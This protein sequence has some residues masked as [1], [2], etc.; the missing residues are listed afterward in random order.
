MQR[1]HGCLIERDMEFLAAQQKG[2]QL[3]QL[4]FV[5]PLAPLSRPARARPAARPGVCP[6]GQFLVTQDQA[7]VQAIHA[8]LSAFAAGTQQRA[9]NE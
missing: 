1:S 7:G 2:N 4:R 3:S 6:E 8:K 5:A 9:G